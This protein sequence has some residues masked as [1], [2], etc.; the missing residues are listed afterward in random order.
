[1]GVDGVKLV[2]KGPAR[3]TSG[4]L[5]RIARE[6]IGLKIQLE[7][8]YGADDANYHERSTSSARYKATRNTNF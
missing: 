2:S 3:H 4:E 7:Y 8:G 5:Q 1:M 6:M